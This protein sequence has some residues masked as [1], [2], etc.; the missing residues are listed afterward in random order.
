[1]SETN[2]QPWSMA[3]PPN[4][5]PVEVEL[6]DGR[7]IEAMAIYGRE[8]TLPHWQLVQFNELRSPGTFRRWRPIAPPPTPPAGDLAPWPWRYEEASYAGHDPGPPASGD[9][10]P[11]WLGEIVDATGR[12]IYRGPFAFN[13]LK[14][15]AN[16]LA[17]TASPELLEACKL[18]VKYAY[19]PE[20][21]PGWSDQMQKALQKARDAISKAEGYVRPDTPAEP[22]VP[23]VGPLTM[24]IVAALE[25][26][27]QL[28]TQ[29]QEFEQSLTDHAQCAHCKHWNHISRMIRP[30]GNT[31]DL[32]CDADCANGWWESQ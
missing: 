17:M 5:Q 2:E 1:M 26:M 11:A 27:Q 6:P 21:T 10:A 15:R 18:V 25:K 28:I 3:K 9:S 12:S 8:G 23:A 19:T 13:S 16:A 14:G 20:S 24:E 31:E 32:V 30:H 4:E 22:E 7:I 29:S